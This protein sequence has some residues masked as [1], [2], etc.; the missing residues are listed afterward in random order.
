MTVADLIAAL[1][2]YPRDAELTL[3]AEQGAATLTAWVRG[4]RFYVWIEGETA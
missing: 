4:E 2:V 1:E 3:E